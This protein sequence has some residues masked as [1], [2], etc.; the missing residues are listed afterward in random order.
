MLLTRKN[1]NKNIFLLKKKYLMKLIII[2]NW[3][4]NHR[5]SFRETS[6]GSTSVLSLPRQTCASIHNY[7]DVSRGCWQRRRGSTPG[8]GRRRAGVVRNG[9]YFSYSQAGGLLVR[10]T[11][12]RDRSVQSPYI[13]CYE[14]NFPYRVPC[15]SVR[16]ISHRESALLQ[17]EEISPVCAWPPALSLS[18]RTPLV[19]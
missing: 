11:L 18:S 13:R 6:P 2:W 3:I 14:I 4:E 10:E 12:Q 8:F 15:W 16:D 9:R 5:K 17:R 1:P 7:I 19:R